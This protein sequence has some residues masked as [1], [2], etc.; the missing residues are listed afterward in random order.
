VK[1]VAGYDLCKLFTGSYGTLGVITELNFKLRPLPEHEATVV[2]V[3]TDD[4]LISAGQSIL[5]AKL[6]PVAVEL[7]SSQTAAKL[8]V[9]TA[10]SS[11]LLVRFAGTAKGVKYQ[12]D[13]S[14][15][16]L[17]HDARV[18]DAEIITGDRHIWHSIA[19][20]PLQH[21]ATL[22]WRTTVL[23]N[24]LAGL[25][26]TISQLYGE[27]FSSLDWQAGVGCG[28]MRMIDS[29]ARTADETVNLAET[30]RRATD[31][32]EGS[33][34]IEHG[35]AGL[36]SSITYGVAELT[37]RIKAQLDPGGILPALSFA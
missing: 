14:V 7:V 10:S 2:A 22:G 36:Q 33:L 28:R 4:G 27:S 24:E 3:G 9:D 6:F 15:K 11:L 8:D 13:E 31:A 23:P 29:T 17:S 30:L 16:L 37:K 5:Q 32:A 26:R 35:E 20:L 18:S 12:M 19:A 34:F 1:N 25:L 21:T